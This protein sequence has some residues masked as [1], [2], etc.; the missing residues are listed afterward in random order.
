MNTAPVID[1]RDHLFDR[2]HRTGEEIKNDFPNKLRIAI[3]TRAWKQFTRADGTPFENVLEWMQYQ[4]P[5]GVS[6]GQG[7][8]TITYEAAIA[9]GMLKNDGNMR[10]AKSA[11][12]KMMPS[13]REEFMQWLKEQK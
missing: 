10:R 7:M 13:E 1:L 4:F 12:R 3:D 5:N 9:A 6:L 2:I 11:F 8:H